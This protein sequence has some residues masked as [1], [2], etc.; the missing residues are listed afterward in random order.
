MVWFVVTRS[1]LTNFVHV[2]QWLLQPHLQQSL[3]LSGLAMI[4]KPKQAHILVS[5]HLQ[6]IRHQIQGLERGCIEFH[7]LR[8]IVVSKPPLAVMGAG[9][10]Q[11]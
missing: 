5:S 10:C 6:R 2:H 7:V 9:F 8:E 11:I 4:Q 3:P 1:P